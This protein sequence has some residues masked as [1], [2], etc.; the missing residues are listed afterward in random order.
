MQHHISLQGCLIW[1]D[2]FA[3]HMELQLLRTLHL[4]L[5]LLH[6]LVSL[7]LGSKQLQDMNVESLVPDG[8]L[9]GFMNWF[10]GDHHHLFYPAACT[11]LSGS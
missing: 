8:C 1:G 2:L 7:C 9:W 3:Y 5:H 6:Q 10:N 4:T 11:K